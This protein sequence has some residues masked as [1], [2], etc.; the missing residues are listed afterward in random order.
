ME[1]TYIFDVIIKNGTIID[2][3]GRQRYKADLGIKD[4]KIKALETDIPHESAPR[5]IDATDK[6]VCPGFIDVHCHT[7]WNVL[8]IPWDDHQER[9][10]VTT[11]IGGLCGTSPLSPKEHL[12]KAEER[13][14]GT[15]YALFAG[16]G[17]IRQEVMGNENRPP[18]QEE[19]NQMKNLLQKAMDE[20]ALGLSTGLIYEPGVFAH[21]EELIEMAKV[22][23]PMRG[24]YAT[25]MRSESDDIDAAVEE[26]ITI[27]RTAQTPLQISHIKVIMPHNWGK[28]ERIIERI[29][30]EQRRG[31]KITADQY[32]YTVTGG[33]YYGISRLAQGFYEETDLARLEKEYEDKTKRKTMVEYVHSLIMERGG[34]QYFSIIKSSRQDIL[35]LFLPQ[36]LALLQDEQLSSEIPLPEAPSSYTFAD[37]I[38][39]ELYNSKGEFALAYHAVSEVELIQFLKQPW[40]MAG[41]D[42]I[43][44]AFHPR[45]HGTFPRILGR[46]ARNMQII[47]LEEAIRKITS[48]PADT[49]GLKGRGQIMPS[50][51]ADVVVFDPDTVI[52]RA[53]LV[54]PNLYPEGIEYVLVNGELVVDN[55]KRTEVF[56]GKAVLRT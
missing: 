12:E 42:G 47:S 55:G 56:P 49:F 16:H 14:L 24:I 27:A 17:S 32:P 10:G 54:S 6:I 39:D 50:A 11:Q 8:D 44:G 15:N 30:T 5:V 34:P 31:L 53:T 19:L 33:G 41:T 13:G 29:Q 38:V 35:G 37:L 4:G 46:Y 22:I 51:I 48:L 36:A 3:T 21:T 45:T 28:G 43:Q 9:Q 23:A 7:D 1:H 18:S 25:H 40:V 20:G 26:A 52:D 2:G